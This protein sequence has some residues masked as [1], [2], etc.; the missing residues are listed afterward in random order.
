MLRTA[1]FVSTVGL[2]AA[3]ACGGPESGTNAG[4]NGS[5][6]GASAGASAG[7]DASTVVDERVPVYHR[8]T[9]AICPSQRGAGTPGLMEIGVPGFPPCPTPPPPTTICCSSD[10]QCD[11]GTNGRCTGSGVEG[12]NVCTYDECFTDSNCPSETPCICR[13][14]PADNVA[15]VCVPGGN[16]V[17]DSD[18]GGRYCARHH[19]PRPRRRN[20]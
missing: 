7:M 2:L 15:N 17:V 20:A 6:S 8:A 14:S 10:S 12:T 18:C 1:F 11:G 9:H 5:N 16:C 19:L 13:S 3:I 4:G